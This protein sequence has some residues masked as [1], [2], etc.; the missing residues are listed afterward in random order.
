MGQIQRK[1]P[2]MY[3]MVQQAIG[4]GNNPEQML[5]EI[6]KNASPEQ[7]QAILQQ[8]KQYGVPENILAQVQNMKW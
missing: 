1:N 5:K 6:K 3:Q 7:I 4:S 8:A 2:Q